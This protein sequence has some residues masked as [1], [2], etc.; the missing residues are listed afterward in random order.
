MSA[1]YDFKNTWPKG[2]TMS[3]TIRREVLIPE[4]IERVWRAITDSASLADWM[5]PND[6]LPR[7]GHHFTFQVP[8]NPKAN[9]EGIIVRCEV[10]DCDPPRRLI[11]SWS[12]GGIENTQVSFQLEPTGTG[13]RLVLEHA[14]FD[15]SQPGIEFA[16]RGAT[17]GWAKM[18]GQ[19]PAVVARLASGQVNEVVNP[20]K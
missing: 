17:Y 18:L 13:T 4:P 8:A 20:N 5:F 3:E 15:L 14:G 16:F 10:L 19:L 2:K 7:V 1:C 12:A 11:F 6:F 9:F